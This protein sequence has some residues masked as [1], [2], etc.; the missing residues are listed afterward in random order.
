MDI[1]IIYDYNLKKLI[2]QYN[3]IKDIFKHELIVY[4]GI[5]KNFNS[6][7]VK[8]MKYNIYLDVIQ[9]D[10]YLNYVAEKNIL[11][12][13]DLYISENIYLRRTYYKDSPLIKINDIIDF[14]FCLTRY[15]YD[16][17]CKFNKNINKNINNIY[18]LNGFLLYKNVKNIKNDKI[19]PKY[20]YYEIDIYSFQ[21]NIIILNTWL[22][23]FI[24][25]NKIL[26]IKYNY[27]NE[28]IVKHFGN[29]IKQKI[30]KN[31][32]YTYK[33]II[34]LD[35]KID[36][37]Y[38]NIECVI[39]NNS[40]FDLII[41]LQEAIINNKFIITHKNDISYDLFGNNAIYYNNFIELELKQSLESYFELN[42][43]NK[44]INNNIKNI[45]KNIDSTSNILEKLIKINKN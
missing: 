36:K 12:V 25:K 5:D 23:Y 1:R 37:Y 45:N 27:K 3:L 13:N 2:N 38:N 28:N 42:N 19:M 30:Y 24:D 10:V 39:I 43:K 21:K 32:T 6:N 11:I 40:Y 44:Y 17:L 22:N 8:K 41:K 9:E 15:S 4:N 34:L 16:I 20:I 7:N 33:N 35:E 14:Y 31:N 26:I 18:L 29:I